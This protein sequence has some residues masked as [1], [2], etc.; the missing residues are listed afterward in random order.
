MVD[1]HLESHRFESFKSRTSVGSGK[2]NFQVKF[3][4]APKHTLTH[5]PFLFI[6]FWAAYVPCEAQYK[7]AV[8]Q[9]LEQIDLIIRLTNKYSNQLTICTS[10]SGKQTS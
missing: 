4:Q 8:Q 5:I 9:T 3:F 1:E 7:D 10:A 6:Q 2:I